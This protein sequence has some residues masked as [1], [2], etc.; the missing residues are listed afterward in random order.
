MSQYFENDPL[1]KENKHYIKYFINN[2][3]LLF[4]SDNGIFSKDYVD[5]GSSLMI[6]TLLNE[7]LNGHGIDLGCGIGVIGISLNYFNSNINF[8]YIDV[9]LKALELTKINLEKYN[10]KGNVYYNNGLENVSKNSIDFVISNP[11]IRAG[12]NVYYKFYEDAFKCL[13]TNGS[14]YVVIQKKQGAESTIKKLKEIFNNCLILE[15]E[16]GYF[17]LKSI[18]L[19]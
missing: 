19:V 3:E 1:V 18:K 5:F 15:K 7:N 11:P 13:K 17:I 4:L 12:K 16:R 10:L 9:N 2:T 14:I 6:K 8:D